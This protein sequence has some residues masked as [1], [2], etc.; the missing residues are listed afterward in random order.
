MILNSALVEDHVF[1]DPS[2]EPFLND[3]GSINFML[4]D[5]TILVSIV[6]ICREDLGFRPM[7]PTR[8]HLAD[9]D[10]DGWYDFYIDVSE[11]DHGRTAAKIVAEVESPYAEDDR[12]EYYIELSDDA[13]K[14][15]YQKI[16]DHSVKQ[17]GSD[18]AAL[19][20]AARQDAA[21]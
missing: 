15:L 20:E 3:D 12:Q 6:D 21:E 8:Q 16:N 1:L 7:F 17:F 19:F 2:A 13:R 18:L 10:T 14:T 11:K 5:T 9:Y 4:M